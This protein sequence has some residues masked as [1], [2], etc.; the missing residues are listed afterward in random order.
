[1]KRPATFRAALHLAA[2]SAS[3]SVA[4]AATSAAVSGYVRTIG[5]DPIPSAQIVVVHL[6]SGTSATAVAA[7]NGAFHQ[8]GLRVGGPYEIRFSADG[9][10][11]RTL[12]EVTL[13]PGTQPPLAAVLLPVGVEEVVATASAV[14]ATAS[15]VVSARDLNNGVGSAYSAADIAGQPSITR[16]VIRTLLRDPLAQSA[17]EGTFPLAGSIRASTASPSMGLCSRTTSAS[18]PARTPPA[19]RRSTSTPWS[20]PRWLHRTIP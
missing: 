17:G 9:F 1:M 11:D 12:T 5:G 2:I 7:P 10:Q 3:A 20:P 4:A 19:A 14:V 16:D 15:A 6:P 8:S 13:T 18:A